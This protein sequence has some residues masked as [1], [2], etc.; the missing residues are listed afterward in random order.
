MEIA[1]MNQNF[2]P[3]ILFNALQKI[4][5][6]AVILILSAPLISEPAASASSQPLPQYGGILSLGS[7]RKQAP[8]NPFKIVDTITSPLMELI[9]SHLV[10]VNHEGSIEPDLAE[11]WDISPDGM[12]YTFYLRKNVRFHDG[13]EC[14]A[15]DVLTTFKLLSDA[16][17]SPDYAKFFE[18]VESWKAPSK[19]VFQAT[20]KKPFSPFLRYL[21]HGSIS[22]AHRLLDPHKDLVAFSK[23]P[24]GTGPFQYSGKEIT[25]EKVIRL[26]ANEQYFF[27][28]PYLEEVQVRFFATKGQVWSAFLRNEIDMMLYLNRNDYEEIAH[29]PDFKVIRTLPA[30]GYALFLNHRDDFLRDKE[31]RE[32]LVAG[33]NR[34]EMLDKLEGGQGFAVNGPFHPHSWA[35][36]HSVT[37]P[38]YDPAAARNLFESKGFTETHGVWEKDGAK[39]E[40]VLLADQGN[41][42]MIRVAKMIRQ[43]LQEIGV[44]VKINYFA[45]MKDLM[46][47][48]DQNVPFDGY[49]FPFSTGT[50]PDT[51]S[52]Y[53]VS[54]EYFNFGRYENSELD[55]LFEEGRSLISQEER[56]MTYQKIHQ[57]LAADHAAI[58]LYIP[59]AFYATSHSVHGTENFFGS[60]LSFF[61]FKE[62]YKV[63]NED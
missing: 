41:E 9:F 31:I 5:R 28:K 44:A 18:G 42:Q 30:G 50:D 35:Y 37:P 60:F 43:Q 36:D 3:P 16:S 26:R 1:K 22:P 58:F 52:R 54:G 29:N 49:L 56:R 59:Y 38:L 27:G 17:I 14:T 4:T 6:V 15:Q 45:D 62:I 8:F 53:W 48:V 11:R 47:K 12:I 19:Y 39:L 61:S 46:S 10:Q 63:P 57:I 7:Y 21:R 20:L 40:F 25:E 24:I 13:S 51:A 33:I 23:A 34:R 32:A 2:K 55:Q